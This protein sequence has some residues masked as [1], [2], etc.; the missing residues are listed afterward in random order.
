MKA[1]EARDETDD[2]VRLPVPKIQQVFHWDCGLACARMATQYV[3]GVGEEEFQGACERL[4]LRD[5][6]WTI[7]LAYLLVALNVRHR[8]CTQTVGVDRGYRNQS[9][10]RR[11]FETDEERVNRLFQMAASNGVVVEKRSVSVGEVERHLA[12]GHIAIVLTDASVLSCDLCPPSA[13]AGGTTA[14][15]AVSGGSPY[16]EAGDLG[17]GVDGD[18]ERRAGWSSSLVS[19]CCCCCCLPALGADCCVLCQRRQEYQGHFVTLCGYS[20]SARAIF[21]NNPAFSDRMC[22]C[23]V[24]NFND[25]RKSYGTDEDILFI[26][27]DS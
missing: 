8:F 20:R 3:R 6:V 1:G 19:G 9:F 4:H 24:K 15:A 7:D 10:Y 17:D 18:A 25:S 16:S 14:A 22:S 23:T 27:K 5:S 21:Y 12:G 11:H 26:Y 13:D 2:F